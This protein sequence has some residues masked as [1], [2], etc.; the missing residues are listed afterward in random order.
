MNIVVIDDEPKIRKGLER[1]LSMHA[2][3]R[4]KTFENPESALKYLYMQDVDAV[5]TDIRM[6]EM[7]G[8][9]MIERLREVN[10]EIPIIILSG[11]SR[12]DYAQRAIELG[13][14]KYMTKPTD[15]QEL[16][17]TLEH[18]Q[19]EYA[20]TAKRLKRQILW[21]EKCEEANMNNLLV[22]RAME[23]LNR[24]YSSHVTLKSAAETLYISPNYL[25]EL[26]SKTA[27]V[28]FSDYLLQ[29]RME[30][31]RFL[32]QNVSYRISD[33]TEMVGFTDSRYFSS[34]FKKVCGMTPKEYRNQYVNKKINEDKTA[35]TF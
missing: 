34:S 27:G 35:G 14:R 30:K 10:P 18:V 2:G 5:I 16:T 25:S 9:D 31:A 4:V 15:P 33:I 29:I 6:P 26:F 1:H 20:E 32:L 13:V 11:Y 28:R 24:N 17:E 19:E 3:W 21:P 12:F 23:Y 22:L 8:L 7:S